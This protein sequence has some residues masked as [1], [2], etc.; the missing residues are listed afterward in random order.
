MYCEEDV[1][2]ASLAVE[3]II[4][5]GGGLWEGLE[6]CSRSCCWYL[7]CNALQGATASDAEG[8]GPHPSSTM[9]P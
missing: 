9:E 7:L 3:S 6:C 1:P 4:R 8:L 2:C 5:L